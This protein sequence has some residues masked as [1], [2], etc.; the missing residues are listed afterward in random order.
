MP[1]STFVSLEA[2]NATVGATFAT[3]T[4]CVAVLP[5][6][7]SESVACAV[8]DEFA[9]PSGKLQSNEPDVFV[10]DGFDFVPFAPQLVATD[11][12]VS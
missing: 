9:G 6:S 4:V 12:I 10:F 3:E 7:R 11:E 1:S 2:E 5:A 8:T